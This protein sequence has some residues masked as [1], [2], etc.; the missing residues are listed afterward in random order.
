[1][2]ISWCTNSYQALGVDE[3]STDRFFLRF[4]NR[5]L[6]KLKAVKFYYFILE[7]EGL[8]S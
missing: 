2:K 1:M 3:I 5:L 8:L 6:I 7:K 4:T